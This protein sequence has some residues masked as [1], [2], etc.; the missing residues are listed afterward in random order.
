[1]TDQELLEAAAWVIG[2]THYDGTPDTGPNGDQPWN[3]L[4]DDG[5][6]FRLMVALGISPKFDGYAEMAARDELRKTRRAIVRAAA[7]L[8][9]ANGN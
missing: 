9:S 8:E 2:R 7:A 5:D 4:E 3:P 6:A 1:M